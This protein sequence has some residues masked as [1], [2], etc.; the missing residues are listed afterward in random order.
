[1]PLGNT[2]KADTEAINSVL[3]LNYVA[4]LKGFQVLINTAAR[5]GME[6]I[7][8]IWRPFWHRREHLPLSALPQR[9]SQQ[10]KYIQRTC[11]D[12]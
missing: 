4:Y 5:E 3:L 7:H 1:M 2:G 11:R 8:S 10:R 12:T 6:P 9:L